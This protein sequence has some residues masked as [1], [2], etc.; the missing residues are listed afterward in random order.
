MCFKQASLRI[1]SRWTC[2]SLIAQTSSWLHSASLHPLYDL[3]DVSRLVGLPGALVLGAGAA[4]HAVLGMNGEL[5]ANV[6]T[7]PQGGKE[8]VNNR[9]FSA[10][11][12]RNAAKS[13]SVAGE[14]VP[15][16]ARPKNEEEEH[17]C[18][19]EPYNHTE[20]AFLGNLFISQGKRGKVLE[21]RAGV[22]TGASNFISCMRLALFRNYG[23]KPVGLGGVFVMEEGDAKLHVMPRFSPC[24]LHSDECV[25]SWLK[26]ITVPPPL[27]CLSVLVSHDPALSLRLEHVHCFGPHG[28]GG[29][30]HCDVTPRSVRYHGYFIPAREI[31]RIDRPS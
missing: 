29:H 4:S 17:G 5:M 13:R 10:R 7:S 15:D 19:L 2:L 18:V 16:E 12:D 22:R 6:L 8:A 11:W 28:L 3:G 1:L 25:N 27:S 30:Y 31:Y 14:G 9:S 23:E 21:I 24:P 26:F 20:F